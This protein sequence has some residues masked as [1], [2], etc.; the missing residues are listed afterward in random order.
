VPEVAVVSYRLG[1]TD[2]VSI[3]AAKWAW[4]FGELGWTVRTVAG[5]GVAD[6]LVEGLAV[7]APAPPDVPALERALRGA[8]L[9]VAENICSL[10]LNPAAG[11]ALARA[12]A[13]RRAVLRHHDLPWERPAFRSFPPPPDAPGWRHVCISDHARRLLG[14]RGIEAVTIHNR[15]EPDPPAGDRSAARRAI[16][17][18]GDELLLLQPTRA[19]ARKNVPGGLALAG[20][21]GATYWLLGGPEDGYDDELE[22]AVEAAPGRVVRGGGVSLDDAYAAC[23][24]V[25]LPSTWEGFGNPTIESATHRRP[26]AVG[27]YPAAR[28][29]ERFGFRWFDAGDPGALRGH[30]DDPD[31]TLVEHN[32]AVARRHFSLHDLPARLGALTSAVGPKGGGGH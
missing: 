23:D 16:G 25:V 24:A 31:P 29:L 7:A 12:L 20:A 32:H 28:E 3:E 4:A 30:L 27:R 13:G 9:V 19:I 15:F 18:A 11:E 17:V 21:V 10:P 14:A 5:E 6:V 2:G 22:R 26:L 8:D 1:G